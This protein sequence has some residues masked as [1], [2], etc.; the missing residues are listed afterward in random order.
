MITHAF[1][2]ALLFLGAGSV[3]HGMHDEQDMRRMGALRKLM[4]ITAGTLHRRLAGHRRRA[5]VRR[6]LVQGRDPRLRL[7]QERG[8]LRRR[9]VHRAA[10]R[11]L[12][13]PRG[14][15][16]LLRR[17]QWEET[18]R[19]RC[20]WE[21]ATTGRRCRRRHDADGQRRS[22]RVP[23]TTGAHERVHPHESPWTMTVPLVVLAILAT[24]AGVPEPALQ[25]CRAL[26]RGLAGAG[27]RPLRRGADLLE[28]PDR[29]PAG[30]LH[31]GGPDRHRPGLPGVHKHRVPTEKVE[32]EF[33][34]KAWYYDIGVS[35]F[36]GGPG[37]RWFDVPGLV[38]PQG[39]RRR[40]QR[41][42][43]RGPG[44]GR[45]RPPPPD[46]LRAQLRAGHDGGR[47]WCW[48]SSS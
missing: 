41:H 22:P 14:V 7:A 34:L 37:R 10:H 36:M 28:R 39:H 3:I 35:E 9:P 24:V 33:F 29:R 42:R 16:G 11:L 30:P 4:P 12:H 5:A 20:R 31:R 25:R 27:H 48:S 23:A 8:P 19:R 38:R 17:G 21:P 43:R 13:E 44:F 26:A 6:L 15:H 18:V 1:F 47:R 2:K 40:R 46:R 45:D 32:P